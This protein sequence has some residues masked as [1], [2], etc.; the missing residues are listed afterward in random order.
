MNPIHTKA[1]ELHANRY[2]A[3][4]VIAYLYDASAHQQIRGALQSLFENGITRH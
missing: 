4:I 1:L 2:T 3:L